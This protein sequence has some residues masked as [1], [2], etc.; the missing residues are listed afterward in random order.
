LYNDN[1]FIL[2][3]GAIESYPGLERKG[4]QQMVNFAYYDFDNRAKSPKFKIQR[5]ELEE[6]FGRIFE[7][8]RK[9]K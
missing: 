5:K 3:L 9:K 8:V 6:I 2:K 4:L 7:K 1:I